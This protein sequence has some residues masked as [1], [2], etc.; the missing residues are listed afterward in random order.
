MASGLIWRS[1]PST[2]WPI[3]GLTSLRP[4]PHLQRQCPNQ[5]P[6]TSWPPELA[7]WRSGG[8]GVVEEIAELL[9]KR[10]VGKRPRDT[11]YRGSPMCLI[12]R[13]WDQARA[14]P[15]WPFFFGFEP[16]WGQQLNY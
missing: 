12:L 15:R 1:V 3:L 2:C 11:G 9:L 5:H 7:V 14:L 13:A 6:G 10:Q 8:Y 4:H 16:D